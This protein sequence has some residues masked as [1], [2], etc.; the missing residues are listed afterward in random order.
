MHSILIAIDKNH[1]AVI[2]D[3]RDGHVF[4]IRESVRTAAFMPD[5][6]AFITGNYFD[7]DHCRSDA[8]G[9]TFWDL[10]PLLEKRGERLMDEISSPDGIVV[11]TALDGPK[12]G[13]APLSYLR[14]LR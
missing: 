11:P 9:L 5:G 1:K 3:A 4:S 2:C 12:V 7:T 6:S 14:G 13:P 10:R 8:T